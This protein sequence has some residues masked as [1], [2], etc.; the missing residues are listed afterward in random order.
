MIIST[1]LKRAL[2]NRLQ[3]VVLKVPLVSQGPYVLLD[4]R[5]IISSPEQCSR[6]AIV[7]PP[8]LALA[9]AFTLASTVLR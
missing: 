1:L 6:R 3:N 5:F 7:L 2:L 8:A 9:L 4:K